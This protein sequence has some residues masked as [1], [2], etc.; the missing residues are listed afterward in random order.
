M[1]DRESERDGENIERAKRIET[2]SAKNSD[3]KMEKE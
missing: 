2:G 1:V 3:S